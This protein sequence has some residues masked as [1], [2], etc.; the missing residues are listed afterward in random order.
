MSVTSKKTDGINVTGRSKPRRVDDSLN[1]QLDSESYSTF[2]AFQSELREM[3]SKWKA[4][5]EQ[6]V[7]KESLRNLLQQ[8]LGKTIKDTIKESVTDQL[9]SIN[10]RLSAFHDSLTFFNE[11]FEEFKVR[12]E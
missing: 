10:E 9:S 11:T 2:S 4:D 6:L 7:T 1:K 3:L 12:L 8:E 5:Q